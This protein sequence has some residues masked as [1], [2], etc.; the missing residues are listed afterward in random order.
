MKGMAKITL[1]IGILC[2][3]LSILIRLTPFGDFQPRLQPLNWLRLADTFILFSIAFSL[4][5]LGKE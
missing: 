1:V 5:R 2:L 4:L 3:L